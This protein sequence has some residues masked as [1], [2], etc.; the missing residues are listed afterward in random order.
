MTDVR[1]N[2]RGGQGA[3][4]ASRLLGEAAIKEG[5]YTHAFPNFGPERAGAPVTSFTRICPIPFTEKTEVYEPDVVVVIDPTLLGEVPVAAG[6][7]PGG[8]IICNYGGDMD[9]LK[10]YF[11]GIDADLHKVD[12]SKIAMEELGVDKPNMIMLGALLKV[13]PLVKLESLIEVTKE[14]F[15]GAIGEKN[16]VAMKR[17]YDEVE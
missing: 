5:Q 8:T 3:V 11:E 16:A 9:T 15:K 14:R 4:T 2:G 17:A 13:R 1:L 7:K 12:G 10:S 6:L